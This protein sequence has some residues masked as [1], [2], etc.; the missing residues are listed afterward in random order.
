MPLMLYDMLIRLMNLTPE[1]HAMGKNREPAI[2]RL[3]WA[4][5]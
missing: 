5:R 1:A 2:W 3:E 4:I